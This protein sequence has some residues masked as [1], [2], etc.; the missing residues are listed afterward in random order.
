[1]NGAHAPFIAIWERQS[2]G[3]LAISIS[4][5]NGHNTT[6]RI[7]FTVIVHGV[8]KFNVAAIV[9]NGDNAIGAPA[10]TVNDDSLTVGHSLRTGYGSITVVHSLSLNDRSRIIFCRLRSW[11]LFCLRLLL[12]FVLNSVVNFGLYRSFLSFRGLFCLRSI[13]RSLIL[14]CLISLR[15]L[16]RRFFSLWSFYRGISLGGFFHQRL[17]GSLHL[18]SLFR[19]RGFGDQSF[20][21]HG[22]RMSC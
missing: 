22:Y 8:V 18:W 20:F 10:I 1:M 19:F 2:I 15:L 21:T 17:L 3:K 6:R 13:S 4:L 7:V 12:C 9:F 16:C 14:S 11:F 5:N